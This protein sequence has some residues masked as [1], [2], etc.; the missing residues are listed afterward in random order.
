MTKSFKLL[1]LIQSS[2]IKLTKIIFFFI[3]VHPCLDKNIA[4]S[5]GE[6]LENLLLE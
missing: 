4:M 6:F 5:I 1:L 3:E 2:K